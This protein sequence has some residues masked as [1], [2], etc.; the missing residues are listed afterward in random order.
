MTVSIDFKT[1]VNDAEG[2][3]LNEAFAAAGVDLDNL[4]PPGSNNPGVYNSSLYDALLL[5]GKIFPKAVMGAR[6]SNKMEGSQLRDLFEKR[7]IPLATAAQDAKAA[8]AAKKD[9]VVPAPGP[10]VPA[11]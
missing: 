8:A 9:P 5:L 11:A 3:Q 4:V 10:K 7:V 1:F 6:L 2:T